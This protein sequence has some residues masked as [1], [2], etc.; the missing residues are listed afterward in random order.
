MALGRAHLC[1]QLLASVSAQE[2]ACQ[3]PS[4]IFKYRAS[5]RNHVILAS[6]DSLLEVILASQVLKKLKFILRV[7]PE[8]FLG[9]G[10]A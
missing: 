3:R 2:P 6:V 1:E 9:T 7:T 8:P 10:G 4:S 5:V